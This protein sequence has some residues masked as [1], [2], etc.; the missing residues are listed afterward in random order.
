M[1]FNSRWYVWMCLVGGSAIGS[2][3]GWNDWETT[4]DAAYFAGV[5]LTAHWALGKG[6]K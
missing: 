1:K 4:F 5:A 2:I 3:G 6:P